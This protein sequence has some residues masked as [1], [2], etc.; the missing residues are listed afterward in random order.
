MKKKV[1]QEMKCN[2][3]I[4]YGSPLS[5]YLYSHNNLKYRIP[6]NG[7]DVWQWEKGEEGGG[8]RWKK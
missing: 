8:Q 3:R 5:K 7:S 4:L 6:H 1:H 2:Y